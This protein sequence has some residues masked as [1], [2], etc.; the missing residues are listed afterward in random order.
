MYTPNPNINRLR[1]FT[2]A[3]CKLFLGIFCFSQLSWD[4]PAM[5]ALPMGQLAQDFWNQFRQ[6]C[7][8]LLT[9][10]KFTC[11]SYLF[12]SLWFAHWCVRWR[13]R[14]GR[15]HFH[16]T[17]HWNDTDY[18]LQ[19]AVLLCGA[20]VLWGNTLFYIVHDEGETWVIYNWKCKW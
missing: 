19:T 4:S 20:N 1:V 6:E 3:I 11:L 17:S 13:K 9:V 15:S 2:H 5:W 14:E 12:F 10:M 8:R 16:A 7:T 18:C